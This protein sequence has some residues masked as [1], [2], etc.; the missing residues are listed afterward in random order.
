M[1]ASGTQAGALHVFLRLQHINISPR[2][3]PHHIC[4]VQVSTITRGD[5]KC[6]VLAF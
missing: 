3:F 5:L 2:D 1:P 4:P 6:S